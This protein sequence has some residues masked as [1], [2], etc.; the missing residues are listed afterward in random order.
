M[1][2]LLMFAVENDQHGNGPAISGGTL[3][4]IGVILYFLFGGSNKDK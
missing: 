4:I 3:L 2:E 1:N